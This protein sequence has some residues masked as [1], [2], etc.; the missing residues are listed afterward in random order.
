MRSGSD[1]PTRPRV[2][3]V[4]AKKDSFLVV[5]EPGAGKTGVLVGLAE[6]LQAKG[7]DSLALEG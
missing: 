1:T 7:R 4:A 2:S 6:H 3:Q 5:G